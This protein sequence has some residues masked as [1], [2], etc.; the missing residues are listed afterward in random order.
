MN[1]NQGMFT[2]R[3]EFRLSLRS[4]NADLRLT[5]KGYAIG[6]V[7]NDR[8]EKF[9]NFKKRY[10]RAIEYLTSVS[11]SI[12]HWKSKIPNLAIQA[13]NP[14][15]KNCIELLRLE[16]TT[17]STF[18]NFIE[19]SLKYILE[20]K[21]LMERIKTYSLYHDNEIKQANEIAE[22]RKHES[23]NLPE[24]FDYSKLSISSESKEK[25]FTFKPTSLG[26]AIRI[27]GIY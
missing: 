9:I 13:D 27:P 5:Q 7:G 26:S 11:H 16:G 14:C 1:L 23:I 2:A 19:P 20:D 3:S 21:K 12:V 22:I 8:Y 24:N 10:D 6:C 15:K 25:L 18:E 4:D 17:V